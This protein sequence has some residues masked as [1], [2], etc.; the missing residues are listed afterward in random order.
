M[1]NDKRI[2]RRKNKVKAQK[3]KENIKKL[4]SSKESCTNS[5]TLFLMGFL[6]NRTLW[7]SGGR[8]APLVIWLSDDIF[9]IF[10][11][12][13]LVFDVKGQ[14]PNARPCTLKI[15]ALRIFWK[16]INFGKNPKMLKIR[17]LEIRLFIQKRPAKIK[18]RQVGC[19]GF[20]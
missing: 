20:L 13:G 7:G 16:I 6:T 15:V 19:C 14:N 4:N 2:W 17:Y 8:S 12:R 1:K 18:P 10:F 5:L 9:N 11:N 3:T